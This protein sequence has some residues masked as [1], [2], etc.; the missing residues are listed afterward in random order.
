MQRI[1]GKYSF[2]SFPL[3]ADGSRDLYHRQPQMNIQLSLEETYADVAPVR[4]P[5][6]ISAFM[7]V[8][9]IGVF[10]RVHLTLDSQLYHARL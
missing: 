6:S 4:R 2:V 8:L 9:A 5:D 1:Q 10:M 7:F 3:A